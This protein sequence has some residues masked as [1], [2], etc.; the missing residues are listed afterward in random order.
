MRNNKNQQLEEIE[1]RLR[2]QEDRKQTKKMKT[3]GKSIFELQ[4]IMSQK[5]KKE[6]NHKED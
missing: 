1:E 5:R 2:K 6:Q 3:S 4:K